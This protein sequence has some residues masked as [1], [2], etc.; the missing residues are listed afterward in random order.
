MGL[1]S[2]PN[3]PKPVDVVGVPKDGAADAAG[4][5]NEEAPKPLNP[6]VG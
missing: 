5:P 2:A 4:V 1:A 6:P 3:P